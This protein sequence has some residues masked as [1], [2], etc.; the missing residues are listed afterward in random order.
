MQEEQAGVE[1]G[2]GEEVYVEHNGEMVSGRITDVSSQTQYE[3]SFEDGSVCSNL[4]PGDIEVSG[5]WCMWLDVC[6][7]SLPG[8]SQQSSPARLQAEGEVER[9]SDLL[10]H[11]SWPALCSSLHSESSLQQ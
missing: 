5:T 11:S 10:H 4:S 8:P 2:A 3:V 9:R 7:V 6:C 1:I